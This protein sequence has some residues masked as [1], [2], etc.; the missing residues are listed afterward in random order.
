MAPEEAVS[1]YQDIAVA[2]VGRRCSFVAMH[3]GTFKLTDE[4]MDEPP[5]LTRA[6]W[7]RGGLDP[8]LLWIPARGE[9]RRF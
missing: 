8:T 4:P 6:A 3:W 2:N 9:T 5:M 1:A 7:D